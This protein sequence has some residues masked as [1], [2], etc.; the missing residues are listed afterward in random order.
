MES[1]VAR[2]QRLFVVTDY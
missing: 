2:G 1:T